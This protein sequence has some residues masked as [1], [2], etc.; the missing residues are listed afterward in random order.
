MTL[1]TQLLYFLTN[2]DTLK[3]FNEFAYT[4]DI[5]KKYFQKE[6]QNLEKT[7][8]NNVPQKKLVRTNLDNNLFSQITDKNSKY[9]IPNTRPI[10]KGNVYILSNY[11]TG[12]AAAMLTTLIQDNKIGTIIGTSV[13]NNPIG[14]TTYTPMEL[15]K[16]KSKISIATTYIVRPNEKGR[17]QIPD[18]W[19]EF[20][21]NDLINGID[22][23][24]ISIQ[25]QMSKNASH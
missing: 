23:Y 24:L 11:R 7:Y 21:I 22:P 15:P 10:F 3:G 6:Y 20:S 16:T 1:A 9:Y 18:I 8:L 25:K 17:I 19:T 4:S 12:S 14:A 5:F 13:G 2:Q